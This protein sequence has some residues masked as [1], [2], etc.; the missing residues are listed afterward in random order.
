[1]VKQGVARGRRGPRPPTYTGKNRTFN[2]TNT[3]KN[4]TP[5]PGQSIVGWVENVSQ[6]S[7]GPTII[8]RCACVRACVR[9]MGVGCA[10]GGVEN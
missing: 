2:E 8:T 10:L 1:M 6:E 9:T 5:G 4:A 3:S 7:G